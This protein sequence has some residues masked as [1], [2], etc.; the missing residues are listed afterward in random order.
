MSMSY[1]SPQHQIKLG[2]LR[3]DPEVQELLASIRGPQV[4]R[5]KRSLSAGKTTAGHKL[6][7]EQ[8]HDWVFASGMAQG[9][10]LLLAVLGL[11][12][13]ENKSE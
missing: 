6:S 5:Y 11:E 13:K 4:P 9:W 1:L 7:E 2:Q 10:D 3:S 8:M 12:R